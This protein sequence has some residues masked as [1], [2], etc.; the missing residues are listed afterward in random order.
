MRGIINRC[1]FFFSY[2]LGRQQTTQ[3]GANNTSKKETILSGVP[4][5]VG[6]GTCA[7]FFIY[8]NDISNSAHRLKFYLF[9]IDTHI[10][11]ADRNLKLLE[12]TVNAELSNVYDWL[13]ANKLSLNIKKSK[14]YIPT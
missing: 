10:L 9:A 1:F 4:Q 14:C 2:L 8:I 7:F 13:T 11:Y 5:R 3:I 12:T 6:T